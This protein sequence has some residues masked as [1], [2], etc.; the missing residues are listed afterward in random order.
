M[1]Y[2]ERERLKSEGW[3]QYSASDTVAAKAKGVL[4]V[5]LSHF[6]RSKEAA[7]IGGMKH[8]GFATYASH[9]LTAN[10]NLVPDTRVRNLL[11]RRFLLRAKARMENGMTY[12]HE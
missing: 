1:R 3:K 8:P 7:T 10:Y 6:Y 5:I 2:N 12:W 9:W 4:M 11:A